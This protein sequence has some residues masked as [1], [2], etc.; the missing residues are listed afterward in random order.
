[1][2]YALLGDLHSNLDDTLAVLHHIK[3][4]D[5]PLHIIALGDLF[6]CKISHKKAKK[7]VD[8]PLENAIDISQTF[9]ELL[10]FPSVIGNQELRI[11]KTTGQA[12]FQH[13]PEKIQIEGATII[14]GHQFTWMDD[15]TPKHKKYENELVFFG[16]SHHSA[17]FHKKKPLTFEFGHEILLKKKRYSINV[18]SVVYHREWCLYDAAVR[19]ITFMKA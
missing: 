16:H 19:S 2:K 7:L 6:E 10:T 9:I 18:G 1:M 5:T 12:L 4:M 15:I 3:S 8:I 11:M 14:H 17:I 13:L